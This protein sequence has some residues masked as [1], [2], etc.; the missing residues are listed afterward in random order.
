MGQRWDWFLL[1]LSPERLHG[2]VTR[3]IQADFTGGLEIYEAI[4]AGLKDLEIGVL[5]M[6]AVLLEGTVPS[7]AP[8]LT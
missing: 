4:K 1:P 5:G 8:M 3:V 2:R 6:S 7:G